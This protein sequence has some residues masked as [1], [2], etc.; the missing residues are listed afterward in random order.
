MGGDTRRF[1]QEVS[2]GK[3]QDVEGEDDRVLLF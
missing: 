1:R 2:N 3:R